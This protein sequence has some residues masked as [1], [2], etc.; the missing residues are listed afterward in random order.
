MGSIAEQRVFEGR[1]YGVRPEA[2]A[3]LRLGVRGYGLANA[4]LPELG[5]VEVPLWAFE[6]RADPYKSTPRYFEREYVDGR[7]KEKVLTGKVRAGWNGW[8]APNPLARAW[9]AFRWFLR[10]L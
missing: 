6:V 10:D 7:I 2:N 3:M 5:K 1:D 9:G 8:W 4:P